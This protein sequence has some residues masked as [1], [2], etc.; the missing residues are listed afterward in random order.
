[1]KNRLLKTFT[2][3][4][5]TIL[6]VI[7][8]MPAF[9]ITIGAAGEPTY[10]KVGLEDIQSTDKII[11][12]STH[13]TNGSFAMSKDNGTSTA[14]KAVS[15]TVKNDTIT[16]SATNILWNISNEDG[17]LTIYPAGTTDTWLYCTNTNNGVRVSGKNDDKVFTLDENT[18]YL[19]HTATSRYLGVYNKAD[20]RC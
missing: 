9:A 14:P 7:S 17:N 8:V 15:V 6:M 4:V 13:S 10:V 11:I 18:G 5:L 16:T 2:S 3:L 1:M 12:V 19:Q 20:W